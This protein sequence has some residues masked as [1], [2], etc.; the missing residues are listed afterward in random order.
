MDKKEE[1]SIERSTATLL[2]MGEAFAK[3]ALTALIPG[4]ALLFALIKSLTKQAA[5]YFRDRAELRLEEFHQR[6]LSAE[7]E[8]DL[9]ELVTDEFS[10]ADY[11]SLLNSVIED[12]EDSKVA[13]YA[14]LM[15]A[16]IRGGIPLANKRHFI[17]SIRE[18]SS[19]DLKVLRELYLRVPSSICLCPQVT[20]F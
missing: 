13:V 18:L 20:A 11:Y 9:R 10:M 2:S 6:L 1:L 15:K 7:S 3:E 14:S 17:K 4:S 16:I 8:V 5:S 12:D 19:D